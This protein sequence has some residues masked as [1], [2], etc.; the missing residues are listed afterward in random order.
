VKVE[1]RKNSRLSARGGEGVG[2]F[3]ESEEAALAAV[4]KMG[5]AS[6][7]PVW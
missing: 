3:A 7:Y 1:P 5:E 4:A 2:A 6:V